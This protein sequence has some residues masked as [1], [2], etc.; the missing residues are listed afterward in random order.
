[1]FFQLQIFLGD[2]LSSWTDFHRGKIFQG[3][4]FLEDEFSRDEFS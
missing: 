3:Q 4:I 1:M 2:E